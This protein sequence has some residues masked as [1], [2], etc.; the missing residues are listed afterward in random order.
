MPI[1]IEDESTIDRLKARAA[2][3]RAEAAAQDVV[4][5]VVAKLLPGCDLTDPSRAFDTRT[6][7]R[8]FAASE[9]AVVY[10]RQLDEYRLRALDYGPKAA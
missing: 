3:R 1:S 10:D 9:C 2:R 8:F 4:D 5:A 7:L 6:S